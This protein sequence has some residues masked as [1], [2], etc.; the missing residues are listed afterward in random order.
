MRAR[1]DEKI[2]RVFVI[3]GGFFA[4][5][6]VRNFMRRRIKWKKFFN[7]VVTCGAESAER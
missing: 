4:T 5:N 6:G 2:F 3:F 7:F 1:E